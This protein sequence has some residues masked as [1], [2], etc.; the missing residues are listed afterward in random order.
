MSPTP[1]PAAARLSAPGRGHGG[2]VRLR[3]HPLA[4]ALALAPLVA[5]ASPAAAQDKRV[6]MTPADIEAATF[7]GTGELP[8]GQS[9]LTA[10]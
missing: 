2:A 4:L 8:P 9:A 5:L 10:K 6:A 1:R 7:S 3:A